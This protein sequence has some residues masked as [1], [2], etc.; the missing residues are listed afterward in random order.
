MK[1]KVLSTFNEQSYYLAR[2]LFGQRAISNLQKEFDKIVNQM[3]ASNEN[4]NARWGSELTKTIEDPKSMVLH[5]HNVQSYSQ[6]MLSMVQNLS[7]IH[8]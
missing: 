5:T 2:G 3:N 7:L 8:I 4:I 6:K 1:N